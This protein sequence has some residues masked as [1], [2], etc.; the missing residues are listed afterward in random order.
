MNFEESITYELQTVS[1]LTNK[2]FPLVARSKSPEQNPSLIDAPYV[3]YISSEGVQTKSFEGFLNYRT[4]DIEIS[5]VHK[6]YS[7]MKALTKLVLAKLVSMEMR[8]IG[9][10]GLYVQALTYARPVELY[11]AEVDLYR[12][13]IECEFTI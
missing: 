13:V 6:S 2:V 8:Q 10:G 4:I 3:A 1:G 5:V 11:E 7:Q 12:S 9:T